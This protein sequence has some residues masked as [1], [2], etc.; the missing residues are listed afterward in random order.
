MI[1]FSLN[2]IDPILELDL[3]AFFTYCLF[4]KILIS[5]TAAKQ[6]KK[7]PEHIKVKFDAWCDLLE[8]MGLRESRKYKGLHDEP[9]KG[10]RQ[11]QRSVRLSKSY[12]AIYIELNN[13]EYEII[14]VIEVNKHE[15]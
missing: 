15:Y 3:Y 14:E 11:G 13:E 6:L 12:R 4:M 1:N 7:I 9:L 5:K 10:K 2:L 8:Y